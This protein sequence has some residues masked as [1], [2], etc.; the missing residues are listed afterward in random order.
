MVVGGLS[1]GVFVAAAIAKKE[2][3]FDISGHVIYPLV[4]LIPSVYGAIGPDID[5][6]N[7][8]SGKVFRSFLSKLLI[9]LL[10]VLLVAVV[11]CLA[12]GRA[13]NSFK[14]LFVLFVVM[15]LVMVFV[16]T[17]KHR[18]VTHTLLLWLV[19]VAPFIWIMKSGSVSLLMD[20]SCSVYF[21]FL[22]GWFSHLLAD[23]FNRKGVPWLYPISRKKLYFATVLTGSYEESIFRYVAIGVF[24]VV[25]VLIIIFL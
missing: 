9:G 25:Y 21:G 4:S 18:G 10:A 24:S 13:V 3:G 8:K 12:T 6:P 23:S 19:I 22:V 17:S 15:G 2:F 1:G 20:I 16:K 7:S 11:F 5:L 14:F